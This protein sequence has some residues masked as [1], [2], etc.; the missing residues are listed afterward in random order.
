MTEQ[1]AIQHVAGW[2]A[3]MIMSSA[4]DEIYETDDSRSEDKIHKA[5]DKVARRLFRMGQP[6]KAR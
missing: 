5:Q 1:E 6:R 4:P 2:A 3:T